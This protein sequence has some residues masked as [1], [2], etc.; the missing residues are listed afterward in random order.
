MTII[1]QT[2]F[3]PCGRYLHVHPNAIVNTLG[4]IPHWLFNPEFDNVS[5][6]EAIDAQYQL[7]GGWISCEGFEHKGKGVL[8]YPG[9]PDLF[10]L[11][12][13]ERTTADGKTETGYQYPHSFVMAMN[14]DGS[15]RVARID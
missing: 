14:D 9:D 15:I 13:Y 2:E 7:G 10:P 4:C 1:L 3:D 5:F 8:G 12:R 6:V 11:V